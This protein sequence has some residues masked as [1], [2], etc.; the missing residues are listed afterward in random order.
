MLSVGGIRSCSSGKFSFMLLIMKVMAVE[1]LDLRMG[2][3]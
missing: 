1:R 3:G 2:Y